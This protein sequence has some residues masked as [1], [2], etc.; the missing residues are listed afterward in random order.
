MK[1]VLKCMECGKA[2]SEGVEEFSLNVYGYP[3]CLKHQAF[4]VD[5][6]SSQQAIDLYFALKSENIPVVLEY[7]DGHKHV[8]IALPGRLYIEVN[9]P[10][11]YESIQALIDL[12]RSVYSLEKNIST[13]LIPNY[14]LNHPGLFRLTVQ[15]LTKACKSLMNPLS[16]SDLDLAMN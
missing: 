10:H 15:E 6:G 8:D 12:R 13:I 5:S 9:G 3:L 16:F 14:L 7:W 1:T 4:I 2:L 11:H